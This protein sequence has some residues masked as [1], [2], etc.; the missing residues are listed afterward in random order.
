MEDS[1]VQRVAALVAL[2]TMSTKGK[3]NDPPETPIKKSKGED[4]TKQHLR[5]EWLR[6][7]EDYRLPAIHE[8]DIERETERSSIKNSTKR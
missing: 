2:V 3:A 7:L 5:R 1:K 6:S 4:D 8:R